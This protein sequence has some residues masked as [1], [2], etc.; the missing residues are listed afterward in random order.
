M[1]SASRPSPSLLRPVALAAAACAAIGLA[2]RAAT[3]PAGAN[4][5]VQVEP[6]LDLGVERAAF[7][8]SLRDYRAGDDDALPRLLAST[9]RMARLRREDVRD[10][11]AFYRGLD[12]EQRMAGAAAEERYDA[13]RV[14][15]IAAG[16]RDASAW[17]AE[18][19]SIE[20]ALETLIAEGRAA[21]DPT[22]AAR[23]LALSARLDEHRV[24]ENRT[25]ESGAL[26]AAECAQRLTR[27]EERA[28]EALAIFTRTGLLTPRLEPLW[29]LARV[30]DAREDAQAAR[31]G[32]EDCDELAERLENDDFRVHALRGL[33]GLAEDSGDLALQRELLRELADIRAPKDDWWLARR[34]A[35]LLLAEDEPSEVVDFLATCPP[36]RADETSHWHW[37]QGSALQRLGRVDDAET[38]F[39]QVQLPTAEGG[40][41]ACNDVEARVWRA[42]SLLE[43]GEAA[44]AVAATEALDDANCAPTTRA[45]RA[46]TLGAA[47]LKLGDAARAEVALRGAIEHGRAYEARLARSDDGAIFGEVVGLET[48]ALLADA[49]ARQD[50]PLEAVRVSETYQARALREHGAPEFTDADVRAWA[51]P[52][53]RGLVTWVVGADT[54]LCAHV[55]ADGAAHAVVIQLGRETLHDAVRRVRDAAIAGD[56]ARARKLAAEIES[57]VV[58]EALRRRMAGAGRLL[59]LAHGPLERMPFDLMPLAGDGP[60]AV[61]PGLAS[62]Q[63]GEAPSAG[64]LRSWSILGDP[65]STEGRSVLPGARSEVEAIARTTRATACTGDAF[66]RLALLDALQS[67]RSLHVAT[68]L[69]HGCGDGEHDAGLLLAR[70]AV[71]CARQIREIGPRLPLA[72]LAACETGE[73]RYVDAQALASV[74]NAFLASGTRNLCVTLWPIEDGAARRWS[75]TFHRELAGGARPSEAAARARDAL[76]ADGTPVSEW[77]AFRFVGRD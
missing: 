29:L 49:L 20:T 55:A 3:E 77:A 76:K 19:A 37:L 31:E 67:G 51:A 34:W 8:A 70:G 58:P 13:L 62:A 68:H 39:A 54:T 69:V 5:A 61:L 72:V 42:Q 41:A 2:P 18:R 14:R 24:R 50:K 74:S 27:V 6:A 16:S 44:A 21:P 28:R 71:L 22:A 73:G 7:A 38:H 53:E 43:R 63:P 17:P 60:I 32:F 33:I 65:S 15:I 1:R 59:A 46:Y 40:R 66:D 52:F 45:Q 47:H 26:T 4:A 12:R 48:V 11:V 57:R 25:G 30:R 75:E 35:A 64:E 36:R 9:D 10:A 56:A 23:A